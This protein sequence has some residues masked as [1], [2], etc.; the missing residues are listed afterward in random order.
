M[1]WVEESEQKAGGRQTYACRLFFACFLF[2][3]AFD[4]ED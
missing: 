3:L 1:S 2:V 4:R